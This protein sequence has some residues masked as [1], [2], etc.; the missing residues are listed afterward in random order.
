MGHKSTIR[1]IKILLI[2]GV[3]LFL[4]IKI[5]RAQY[6]I[7]SSVPEIISFDAVISDSDG[8]K[9]D[10]NYNLLFSIYTDP[11]GG[12]PVWQEYHNGVAIEDGNVSV[13]L[14][15]STTPNPLNIDFNKKYYLGIKFEDQNE[16]QPRIELLPTPYSFRT[17]I[18]EEVPDGSIT[19]DKIAPLSITNDKI[20]SISWD[21]I[22]NIPE[23]DFFDES[24]SDEY[25][26]TYELPLFWRR[27]GNWLETG[28]EFLGTRND[29]NLVIKTDSVQRMLFDP[30]GK[31]LMGTPEDSVFFEVIGNTTL[32]DVY[33]KETMG[34]G[35]D[36]DEIEGRLHIDSEGHQ[37]PFKVDYM[38]SNVFQI[39]DDGR[40]TII[41]DATGSDDDTGNYPLYIDAAD[42]GIAVQVEGTTDGDHNYMTFWDDDGIAG[43]IEGQNVGEYLLEPLNI[44]HDVWFAGQVTVSI[45]AAAFSALE[46]PDLIN[47][48]GEIVYW[49]FENAWALLHLGV[50]Y[51]S[52]SGD[53]AE[54][55]EKLDYS[56][57]FSPGDIVGIYGGKISKITKGADQIMSVSLSPLA[58]GNSPK[59]ENEW[60]YEKV[61]FKG[62]VLVK[63][64]GPVNVGDYIIPSGLDDGTGIAVAAELMTADEFSVALGTAWESSEN[65]SLN[66]INV[67]VGLKLKDLSVYIQKRFNG[68]KSVQDELTQKDS[69]LELVMTQIEELKN[70]SLNVSRNIDQ[71][72]N[73]VKNVSRESLKENAKFIR[74]IK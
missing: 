28:E 2:I 39:D 6:N 34:V 60:K 22:T 58:L 15:N 53:Y 65:I 71:L 61:A 10:G 14:G 30:Y 37:I 20:K 5:V 57:E 69:E 12:E 41:S 29:R 18:A 46:V 24:I 38:S 8:E 67:A 68:Y 35:V 51:E 66:F 27:Y 45:V 40:V 13:Q 1:E 23:P 63:V 47:T 44:A 56:E 42:Q 21:K 62:Q 4:P 17:K 31:V 73:A 52:S 43:R 32:D 48:I 7:N 72:I 55:L 74:D 19:S 36:F 49:G 26:T 25:R 9:A 64:N 33:V 16:M 70:A 54:W 50:T 11:N 59:A 3:L